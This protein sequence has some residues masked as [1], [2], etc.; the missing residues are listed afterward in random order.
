MNRKNRFLLSAILVLMIA[1]LNACVDGPAT[2]GNPNASNSNASAQP[3]GSPAQSKSAGDSAQPKGKTDLG[4]IEI[5]SY[6][7]GAGVILISEDEGGA[8][9][10]QPRGSTP[11][12]I[13]DLAP[14]KYSLHLELD[15]YKPY[16]KSIEVKAGKISTIK[17]PLQKK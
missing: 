9:L 17:T 7:A 6:P 8:G 3:A 1:I 5:I 16:Q 11:T 14:G 2:G 12:V 15:G 4:T 10:P 13:N